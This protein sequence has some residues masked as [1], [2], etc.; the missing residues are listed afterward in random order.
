MNSLQQRVGER[1]VGRPVRARPEGGARSSEQSEGAADP[2]ARGQSG[3]PGMGAAPSWAPD[4]MRMGQER[5][6]P[7]DLN[8]LN[9]AEQGVRG[10]G[11]PLPAGLRALLEAH[12][13]SRFADIRLHTGPRASDAARQLG[14]AAY[15]LGRDIG[16][17]HGFYAPHTGSGLRLLAHELAHAVQSQG[18][19]ARPRRS[20]ATTAAL[21]P[22]EREAERGSAWFSRGR[23]VVWQ[24]LAERIPLCH[25]VYIS[26]HGDKGYLDMAAKFYANWGYAPVHTA[27]PSIEAILR[28]LAGQSS[29]DQVTIV[30]HANPHLM[31]IQFIDGG[32]D[33]VEK[34]DWQVDTGPELLT[35]DRHLVP[36]TMLDQVIAKVQQASPGVLP[37]IG[38]VSDP[39][40]G[41]FIWWVVDEVYAEYQGFPAAQAIR[42]KAAV[43]AHTAV[44]RSRVLTPPAQPPGAGSGQPAVTATDV[45]AAEQAM[46]T[47]ALQW[48]WPKPGS[49]PPLT[50][51]QE[52]RVKESPSAAVLRIIQSPDFLNNLMTVRNKIGDASWIEV[53][54]CNAGADRGYLE[55][56]QGFFGGA[57]K[58]P[59]VT[60]PD[61]FQAFGPYGWRS[62]PDTP[63]AAL[64]QW[65]KPE[66]KAA[67]T[68]WYPI[69]TGKPLPKKPTEL[70][71]LKYLRQGHALPLAV[72]DAPGR[73]RILVLGTKAEGALVAWLSRHSYRLTSN[74]DI[75]DA[76]FSGKDF[77]A[78]VEGAVVDML[79]EQLGAP[80]KYIFRAQKSEYDKH[81]IEVH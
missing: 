66:V 68:Y 70:T 46:R 75:G 25:P 38:P 3:R 5:S 79:K 34:S 16:F 23:A 37:R 39:V 31:Q 4:G 8:R 11:R 44:Y 45:V 12:Y 42:L 67:L 61:W 32:P 26:A 80:T 18:A 78:N 57:A 10:V 43:Q 48:Q 50:H 47:Q 35:L 64:A 21:E 2:V 52:Q 60:A 65:Q 24:R 30:S 74:K 77:G 49:S 58:K 76:L 15:T 33:Q 56:I 73:A 63:K 14:A 51:A 20:G 13:G 59:K 53:Q 69:I 41:Q 40:V 17:G 28:D 36:A 71:L 22:L 1:A 62:I 19:P 72:P 81:I 9:W 27:V 29:I 55:G 6:S 54:G 7:I